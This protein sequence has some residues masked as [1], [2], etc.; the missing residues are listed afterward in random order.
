MDLVHQAGIGLRFQWRRLVVTLLLLTSCAGC[1]TSGPIL[2]ASQPNVVVFRA[3][4]GYFPCVSELEERMLD[5]GVC[6]TVALPGAYRQVAERIIGAR[7][8][9]RLNG[10][11]V[12]VGYSAGADSALRASRL[13]G[14]CGITVDKLVLLE[15]SADGC[16]PGNVKE[17]VNIY[18]PQV[19]TGFF[20]LFR[21]CTVTAESPSTALVN[22]NVREYNDG[23]YD[24]DNHFTLTFN[25]YVRDL[26]FDEV[27][28]A[29]DGEPLDEEMLSAVD[30]SA[31]VDVAEEHPRS[32]N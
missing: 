23:R 13:L 19:W 32:M 9:D 30:E 7:N 8:N 27:M 17:C 25:P 31:E 14:E 11:L 21:G 15:A 18:K 20:P 22:Y 3:V 1:C 2:S 16:V 28:A 12:I 24:W 29:I 4:A 6:P 10:P 5:E 26:M